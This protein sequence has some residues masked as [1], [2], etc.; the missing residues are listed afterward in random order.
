MA[1][2]HIKE[3]FGSDN[4]LALTEK[5][6]FNFDQLI[7][8][9]GGP[10]GPVGATGNQGVAGPEG[11]RGSQWIGGTG[12]TGTINTPTDGVLRTN[13]F[14]L[15]PNGDV[16]YYDSGWLTTGINLTGP[17]GPKGDVGDGAISILP[18]LNQNNPDYGTNQFTPEY[19]KLTTYLGKNFADD[20]DDYDNGSVGYV[21]AGLDFIGVGRGNNS[22]VLGRYASIFR[23]AGTGSG[24]TYSPPSGN[25]TMENFPANEADVPMLIIAQNDYKDPAVGQEYSNGISIGLAK[26]HETG[27]YGSTE[28]YSTLNMDYEGFA[29]ISMENRYYDFKIQ[30]P[31]FIKLFGANSTTFRLGARTFIPSVDNDVN[32]IKTFLDTNIYTEF[33]I[34]DTVY[35]NIKNSG[36]SSVDAGFIVEDEYSY[37]SNKK[38]FNDTPDYRNNI[39]KKFISSDAYTAADANEIVLLNTSLLDNVSTGSVFDLD[40]KYNT[41][42]ETFDYDSNAQYFPYRLGQTTFPVNEMDGIDPSETQW[43][44]PLISN[45]VG[46]NLSYQGFGYDQSFVQYSGIDTNDSVPDVD[47]INPGAFAPTIDGMFPNDL[48]LET[49]LGYDIR[50][51]VTGR[52]NPNGNQEGSRS[53]SRIGLYPGLFRDEKQ[54]G[55]GWAGDPSVRGQKFFDVAH[56]MLPTGSIDL[57]G[58]VRLRQQET[59]DKGSQDGWVAINKKD[60]IVTFE[61]PNLV[62]AVPTYAVIMFPE[63]ASDKFSF[64]AQSGRTLGYT[65]AAADNAPSYKP[66]G[67]AITAAFPG[68]GS[69][70]LKDYYICNGAVL[71]DSR[72]ILVSGPYGQ[73]KGMNVKTTNILIEDGEVRDGSSLEYRPNQDFEGTAGQDLTSWPYA[74]DP[75]SSFFA[76]RANNIPSKDLNWGYSILAPDEAD[77]QFRIVLPNYFGRLPKMVFPDSEFLTRAVAGET[78]GS[79]NSPYPDT[80]VGFKYYS[81]NNIYN[82]S[83]MLKGSFESLGFPYLKGDNMPKMR[84]EVGGEHNHQGWLGSG[85]DTW[86]GGG[87][88]SPTQRISTYTTSTDNGDHYHWIDKWGELGGSGEVTRILNRWYGDYNSNPYRTVPNWISNTGGDWGQKFIEPPF[89]GT[90][91]AINLK[92]ARNPRR[93]NSLIM[94]LHPIAGIPVCGVITGNNNSDMSW[95]SIESN[96]TSSWMYNAYSYAT[97]ALGVSLTLNVLEYGF[98][99]IGRNDATM[100]PNTYYDTSSDYQTF[101]L[102]YYSDQNGTNRYVSDMYKTQSNRFT[103]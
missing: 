40:K 66:G 24:A 34:S 91:M 96:N 71:A 85:P 69:E 75:L 65:A 57:Y 1:N 98:R 37:N 99:R 42:Q 102:D 68:K 19:N 23:N 56:R 26:T 94:D 46:I 30:A 54:A 31:R 27:Q 22:L 101:A 36:G 50:T 67:T 7:L 63:M 76:T 51:P 5:I 45:G 35:F 16:E 44:K 29:N 39:A 47:S 103:P 72:D 20:K 4:I 86:R 55:G 17:Q 61:E 3:L 15:L 48:D 13:D 28:P 25:L 80:D 83:W 18:G 11:I 87:N 78:L 81:S 9:G 49:Y 14:K 92:G 84:T 77:S 32:D 33:D 58:T 8:A 74:G 41:Y 95:F 64:F 73:M 90:F 59:T 100:H 12:A 93:N 43:N 38:L 70:E 88:A 79:T 21:N 97:S 10:E 53:V 52:N 2:I 89:K 62:N 60:G 82:A 6:N